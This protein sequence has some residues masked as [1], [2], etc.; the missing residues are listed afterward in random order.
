MSITTTLAQ[1]TLLEGV[2]RATLQRIADQGLCRQYRAG[3]VIVKQGDAAS[4]LYLVLSGRV[5]VDRE[6]D[7][8]NEHL[9]DLGPGAFF[10]E[11]ALIE[12]H[13]RTASVT[14]IEPSECLLIVSW[15]FTALMHEYPRVTEALLRELITRVHRLE[16]HVF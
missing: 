14:A 7:G 15:E 5:R 3:Q 12:D 10:G 13:P 6:H 1:S 11:M 9:V 8:V 16:H 4:A 2:D